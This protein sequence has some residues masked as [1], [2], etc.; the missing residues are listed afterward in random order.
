M[1]TLKEA[2]CLKFSCPPEEFERKVFR[3]VIYPHA[4]PL[5]LFNGHRAQ[6]FAIDRAI[7][8]YCGSLRSP[9]EIDAEVREYA[10]LGENRRFARRRLRIRISGRRLKRLASAC[11][12]PV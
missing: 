2:F 12:P 1:Q 9:K 10:Q 8:N 5:T 7:I 6:R 4:W 3:A 11:F